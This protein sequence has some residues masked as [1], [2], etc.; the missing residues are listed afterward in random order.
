M[1][2][3]GSRWAWQAFAERPLLWKNV[4]P[5]PASRMTFRASPMSFGEP[6]TR[7]PAAWGILSTG[8]VNIFLFEPA[9]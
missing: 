3:T 9:A 4:G 1:Y 5:V 6:Q 7:E 8:S 2:L